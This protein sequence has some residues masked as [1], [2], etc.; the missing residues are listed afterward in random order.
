MSH[1]AENRMEYTTA[2]TETLMSTRGIT[3]ITREVTNQTKKKA[4]D[5]LLLFMSAIIFY[6]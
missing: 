6:K 5:S 2:E 3:R 1:P 4:Q